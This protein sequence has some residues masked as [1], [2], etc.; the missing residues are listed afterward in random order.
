MGLDLESRAPL[1]TPGCPQS[2]PTARGLLGKASLPFGVLDIRRRKDRKLV[3][4]HHLDLEDK[5]KAM[6]MLIFLLSF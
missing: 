1:P 6:T 5:R 3:T 2:P 4:Y